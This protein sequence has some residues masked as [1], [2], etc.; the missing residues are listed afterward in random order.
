[1]TDSKNLFRKVGKG[2]LINKGVRRSAIYD[3]WGRVVDSSVTAGA[4]WKLM[5]EGP[6]QVHYS[7]VSQLDTFDE[8]PVVYV[9]DLCCHFG[10]FL[11]ETLPNF[12]IFK[13]SRSILGDEVK[14]LFSGDIKTLDLDFYKTCMDLL[15]INRER[16]FVPTDSLCFEDLY[17]IEQ[18]INPFGYFDSASIVNPLCRSVF[19]EV[20]RNFLNDSGEEGG[21][22]YF[23][24]RKF[25]NGEASRKVENEE[26]IED[27][28]ESRGY[29]IYWPETLRFSEQLRIVTNASAMAGMEGSAMHLSGFLP[30]GAKT[31][32]ISKRPEICNQNV[33][34]EISNS[35]LM[36]VS[37]DVSGLKKGKGRRKFIFD[38]KKMNFRKIKRGVIL[39]I[40]K[41][42]EII[43]QFEGL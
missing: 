1:M 10:H 18:S 33:F 35:P 28:F 43:N 16:L 20:R 34:C 32:V 41:I 36:H 13:E 19:Q 7:E 22:V 38:T 6:N 2:F 11:L 21:K 31:L 12:W 9:G 5:E 25:R 27:L 30:S 39:D 3:R 26:E 15:G 4:G 8:G 14:F 37:Y 29:T 17:C 23:S 42:D 24:R 40:A